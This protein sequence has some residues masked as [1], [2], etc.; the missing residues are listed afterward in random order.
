VSFGKPF[1]LLL[2]LAAATPALAAAG[3]APEKTA[4]PAR[5]FT[6]AGEAYDAGDFHRAIEAYEELIRNGYGE[7][8]VY[9]NLGNAY[10]RDGDLA[11]AVIN[12][13]RARRL[14]PRDAELQENLDYCRTLVIDEVKTAAAPGPVQYI[15]QPLKSYSLNELSAGASAL[16]IVAMLAALAAIL[17]AAPR[18]KVYFK[19]ISWLFLAASLVLGAGTGYI[20][21]GEKQTPPAVVLEDRLEVLAGP[22]DTFS[23]MFVLHKG[24]ETTILRSR[25]EWKQILFPSAGRGWVH[26]SAIEKI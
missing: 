11:R 19:R 22:G 24:A 13:R 5:L 23:A 4:P 18:V 9:Y 16:F 3:P 21:H 1:I 15:I 8:V 10:F 26:K 17:T 20:I 14:M 7:G 25:G 12:Y 6:E 2:I